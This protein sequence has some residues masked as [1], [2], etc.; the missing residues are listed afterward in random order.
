MPCHLPRC[1][2][3]RVHSKA[4]SGHPRQQLWPAEQQ[5][6]RGRHHQK[7]L[8]RDSLGGGTSGTCG[9]VQLPFNPV[10]EHGK[11]P[12]LCFMEDWQERQRHR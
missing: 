2:Q 10:P 11:H 7:A 12:G 4:W 9:G 1:V 3:P 5:G 6:L 8:P